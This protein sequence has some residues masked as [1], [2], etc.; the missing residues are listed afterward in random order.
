MNAALVQWPPVLGKQRF[1]SRAFASRHADLDIHFD[2]PRPALVT[3]L[4]SSCLCGIDGA[5]I[6][7]QSLWQWTVSE[8]LQGLLA[9]ANASTGASTAAVAVCS[10]ADCREQVELQLELSS[11]ADEEPTNK[12]DWLSPEGEKISC[13]LPTGQDQLAWQNHAQAE[14]DAQDNDESWLAKRLIEHT[15]KQP[16]PVQLPDTWI[17]SLG[18]ALNTADPLTALDIDVSCPFCHQSLRVDVDLEQ[19]LIEGLRLQQRRLIEQIHRLASSYHWSETDIAS[20]PG[21]RR[22]RYLARVTT[23]FE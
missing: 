9:I 18:I 4:L 20:L 10:N 3:E 6:N 11:F 1:L 13:R 23:E 19:L 16:T 14:P 15:A 8:R 5:A 7:A 12:F 22:E 2:L 21:W 17:D